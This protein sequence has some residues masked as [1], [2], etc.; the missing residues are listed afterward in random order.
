M[1]P[2]WRKP[3]PDPSLE[4]EKT[5]LKNIYNSGACAVAFEGGEPLL[6]QDLT[7]ILAFSRSLPLHTSLITNGTLLESR[8]DEIAP[9]INGV[10]YVSLDGLEKTHDAIRGVNG[11][12]RKALRGIR[13][14]KKKVAVTINTTVMSENITEIESMVRLAKELG[15]KISIAVAHQYCNADVSSPDA[16]KIPRIAHRLMEMKREGYPVVNSTGYFKVMAKE[17]NWHCK[18]W[19]TINID[20]HGNLVLPCYVR[21]DYSSGTSV[22]ERGIKGAISD[23]DWKEMKDCQ[24]CSLHCY[25]EP[26]LVLS[27]DISAYMHWAFQVNS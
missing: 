23:F 12:F 8:I 1:C 18:P 14:A 9:Y 24:R 16:S 11:S 13:A 6:R 27:K 25:V 26:S 5:I 22:L 10:V 2:F 3:S 17:K 7:E 21:N 20:P 19:A 15:T 4:Q